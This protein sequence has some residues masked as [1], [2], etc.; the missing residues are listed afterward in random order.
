LFRESQAKAVNL[1]QAL[2]VEL[3]NWLLL[4]QLIVLRKADLAWEII[5]VALI[6]GVY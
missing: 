4:S 5:W 6:I 2:Q 1:E 3:I